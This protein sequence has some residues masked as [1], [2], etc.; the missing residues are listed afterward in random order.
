MKNLSRF[1]PID[2]GEANTEGNGGMPFE[3]GT[4]EAGSNLGGNGDSSG[5]EVGNIKQAIDKFEAELGNILSGDGIK[6]EVIGG[7]GTESGNSGN[8]IGNVGGGY[9]GIGYAGG[10]NGN[11]GVD[12]GDNA[13]SGN[14][15]VYDIVGNDGIGSGAANGE[16]KFKVCGTNLPA[17][18]SFW[19]RLRN[20][21][22]TEIAIELSSSK[23][24]SGTVSSSNGNSVGGAGDG[25]G[26][27]T[28]GGTGWSG[29]KNF[30][31]FGKK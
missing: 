7:N 2:G 24:N 15:G 18:L 27:N 12:A 29:L 28:S 3:G 17:K 21:F 25:T 8:E 16:S 23:K 22:K 9:G 11:G 5:S 26:E 20:F 14:S 19:S 30:F 13:S 6:P 1:I 4:T 31:S 10:T